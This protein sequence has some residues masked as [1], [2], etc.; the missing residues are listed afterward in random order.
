MFVA[1]RRYKELEDRDYELSLRAQIED[2][3]M[4]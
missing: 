4:Y 2:L 3:C 1:P